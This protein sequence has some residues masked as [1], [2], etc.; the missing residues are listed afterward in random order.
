MNV[1]QNDYAYL[2]IKEA[3]HTQTQHRDRAAVL[4]YQ[5]AK[6]LKFTLNSKKIN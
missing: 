6:G 3:T 4:I 5:E 2:K 1:W